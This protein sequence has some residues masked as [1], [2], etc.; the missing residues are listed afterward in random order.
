MVYANAAITVGRHFTE[1]VS[2]WQLGGDK[3]IV[4]VDVFTSSGSILNPVPILCL[5]E[6]K[7]SFYLDFAV[8][9]H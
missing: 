7:V 2:D 1:N 4:I 3:T 6:V 8:I 9:L 5:A